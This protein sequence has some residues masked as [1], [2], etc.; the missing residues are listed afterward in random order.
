E[1]LE[2][3]WALDVQLIQRS[4]NHVADAMAK[5]ARKLKLPHAKWLQAWNYLLPLLVRDCPHPP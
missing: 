4:A 3:P 1:F 2:R 5:S